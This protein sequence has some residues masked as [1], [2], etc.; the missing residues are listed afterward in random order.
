M[1][2]GRVIVLILITRPAGVGVPAGFMP[3]GIGDTGL[4]QT[5]VAAACLIH[6]PRSL[7]TGQNAHLIIGVAF[8]IFQIDLDFGR[9]NI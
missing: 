3:T 2:A 9:V 4:V 1:F 5:G 8:Q 6:R 7:I